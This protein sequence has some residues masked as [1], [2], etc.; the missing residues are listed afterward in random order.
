MYSQTIFDVYPAA[1]LASVA[2]GFSSAI[3][4]LQSHTITE[5][6]WTLPIPLCSG[7]FTMKDIVYYEVSERYSY[8][9]VAV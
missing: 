1:L 6:T 4:Y 8:Y 9:G 3:Q 5:I 7:Q 2:Y